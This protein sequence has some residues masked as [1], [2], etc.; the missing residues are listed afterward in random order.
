MSLTLSTPLVK[1]DLHIVEIDLAGFVASA[2]PANLRRALKEI[3]Q[4]KYSAVV[5]DLARIAGIDS[6][7]WTRLVSTARQLRRSGGYVILRHCPV[8]MLQ[9]L[10]TRRWDH[11]FLIPEHRPEDCA[12]L[13][14][15]LRNWVLSGAIAA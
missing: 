13:P 9:Q 14:E 2:E 15:G 12:A 8:G 10:Q 6:G 3:L 11:C 4:Q 7:S 5:V 1:Q